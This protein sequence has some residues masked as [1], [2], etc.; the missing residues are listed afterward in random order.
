MDVSLVIPTYNRANLIGKTIPALASQV[1]GDFTYEVIF[2]SNGSSDNTVEVL[3]EAAKRYSGRIRY[4][5]IA[6]TGGPSAPRNV[7]I[8]AAQGDAVIIL[9]DDV[10]PDPDLMLRHAEFHK[11]HPEPQHA[12]ARSDL[13][14]SRVSLR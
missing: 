14:L 6:P 7:G 5:S 8:R 11:A 9:D 12:A 3:K 13:L 1:T 2:V 4:Y 10:L